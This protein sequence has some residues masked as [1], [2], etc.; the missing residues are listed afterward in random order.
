LAD[1]E[2]EIIPP[3]IVHL[4]AVRKDA[5]RRGKKADE[6]LLDSSIH[7]S[8]MNGLKGRERRGRPDIVHIS[9]LIANESILN[10]EEML[11]MVVHTRNDYVIKISPKMRVVKNYNRFKGLVEQLFREREVPKGEP[12]MK[13]DKG[14]VGAVLDEMGADRVILLSESGKKKKLE[15]VFMENTVCVIGGFPHGDFISPV[16]EIAD[17]IIS[18][19]PSPLPA[20]IALMEVVASYERKFMTRYL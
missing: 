15:D 19:Y 12:L 6:L 9:V 17:E 5:E 7:H 16:K 10:K 18:V 11:D 14:N 8:A 4:P 2:L 3:E 20:W 13:I 1:S